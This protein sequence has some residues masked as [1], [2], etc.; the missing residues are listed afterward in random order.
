[1]KSF[2]FLFAACNYVMKELYGLLILILILE[3]N[4]YAHSYVSY[5][6]C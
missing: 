1:M 6:H 4:S 5:G 2:T 3:E